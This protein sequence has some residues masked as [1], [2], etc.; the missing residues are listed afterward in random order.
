MMV[1]S[2]Y[3][4][5]V[6]L[7]KLGVEDYGIYNVI[8]SFAVTFAFFSSTLTNATQRFLTIEL[9]RHENKAST[10]FNQHLIVYVFISLLVFVIAEIVG[11]WYID[12]KLNIPF[13]RVN[14]ATWAF[15]FSILSIVIGIIA[16]V[17]ESCFVAH[18]EMKVYAYVGIG[19]AAFKLL[20]VYLLS[21][22]PIDKLILYSF[23]VFLVSFLSKLYYIVYSHFKFE[24]CKLRYCYDRKL[25]V[26][27]F[28]FLGWSFVSAGQISV[29]DQGISLILNYF[30]GPLANAARGI[31]SQVSG[32]VF[33]FVNS[34]LI[35]FQPQ[36]VK[37][38]ATGDMQNLDSLFNNS[39]RF[40]FFL[41]WLIEIPILFCTSD[42]LDIWL[43]EVPKW[44]VLMVKLQLFSSL[45]YVLTKPI[46]IIIIAS[47]NL[48]KYTLVTSFLSFLTFP[49]SMLLLW[50]D[51][52]PTSVYLVFLLDNIILLLV[53][54][55]MV[56]KFYPINYYHYI[57]KV[58][59]P[60]CKVLILSSVIAL[61]IMYVGHDNNLVS[62]IFRV[63]TVVC[64]TCLVIWYLGFFE[65]ERKMILKKIVN[66]T[67]S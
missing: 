61:L 51:Y 31:S 1:I 46:W 15:H 47:G 66:I 38:Y 43:V 37:S 34:I 67:K 65:K 50:M 33:K 11:I 49:F 64:E 36:M 19:E 22:T 26:D 5:R 40:S 16:I 56:Q 13:E 10:V 55:L 62:I 25:I 39:S 17:Y 53:Q 28:K 23:L 54:L 42:L 44:T 48:K 6:V 20:I 52:E 18:E 63:L 7:D 21:I 14:A 57:K 45:F 41:L 24:E 32:V 3:T 59:W 8:A 58:V 4:S 9:G 30:C 60:I 12:N 27:T 35:S 29:C 2:L